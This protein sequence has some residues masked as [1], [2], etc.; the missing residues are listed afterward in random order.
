M[1]D[2][3][4]VK[5]EVLSTIKDGDFENSRMLDPIPLG[6]DGKILSPKFN[7]DIFVLMPKTGD[8][9]IKTRLNLIVYL[10]TKSWAGIKPVGRAK[11]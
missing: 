4:R 5:R 11:A 1:A 8:W 9:D 3:T 10:L 7:I 2:N 6:K